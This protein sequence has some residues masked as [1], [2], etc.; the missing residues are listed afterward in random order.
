MIPIHA[1]KAG[2]YRSCSQDLNHIIGFGQLPICPCTQFSSSVPRH[3]LSFTH[4]LWLRGTWTVA[5]HRPRPFSYSGL[6]PGCR[7]RR[8]DHAF[9]RRQGSDTSLPLV[10]P[11]PLHSSHLIHIMS[12]LLPLDI[13]PPTLCPSFHGSLKSVRSQ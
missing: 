7:L 6:H 9:L 4:D 8:T 13:Q 5:V 1:G 2:H 11:R 3:V 12:G 10:Y